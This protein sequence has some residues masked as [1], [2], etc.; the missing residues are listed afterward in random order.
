MVHGR[1]WL[2]NVICLLNCDNDRD[3]CQLLDAAFDV[4]GGADAG[5]GLCSL[6]TEKAEFLLIGIMSLQNSLKREPKAGL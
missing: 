4:G 2:V 5:F 3:L 6:L 1:F